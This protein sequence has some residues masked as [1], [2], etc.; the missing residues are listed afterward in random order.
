MESLDNVHL[1]IHKSRFY[2][3]FKRYEDDSIGGLEDRM[4]LPHVVWNKIAEAHQDAMID[5]AQ[6]KPELSPRELVVC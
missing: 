3:W 2:N 6:E 1:D 5:L 4:P